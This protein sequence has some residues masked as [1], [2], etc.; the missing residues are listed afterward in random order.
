VGS[1]VGKGD[2]VVGSPVVPKNMS[3]GS[4]VGKSVVPN[5]TSIVVSNN[6]SVGCT[7]GTPVVCVVSLSS[8]FTVN[9]KLCVLPSISCWN[10]SA[11]KSNP[12]N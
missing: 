1:D 4:S 3:V 12:E 9:L 2:G 6:I 5:N 11:S 10:V 8:P 7:V